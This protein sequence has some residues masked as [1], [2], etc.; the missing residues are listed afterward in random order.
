[1]LKKAFAAIAAAFITQFAWAQTTFLPTYNEDYYILDRL[2]TRSGR[3]SDT[4][5]VANKGE[6]RRNA[7]RFLEAMQGAYADSTAAGKDTATAGGVLSKIDM[8]NLRQMISESGEWAHDENGALYAKK[9]TLKYL[10]PKDYNMAYVKTF[11]FFLVVNPIVSA[12]GMVQLNDPQRANAGTG[13]EIPRVRYAS[14]RGVELRGWIGKKLGF[15]TSFTDN[16]E[17]FPYPVNN[18]AGKTLQAVPGA[19]YFK[20]PTTQF[21]TYDYLQA[22]GYVN[23]DAV[24]DVLNLTFGYGKNSIGDGLTSLYLTDNSASMPYI[25]IQTRIW[26]LNYECLYTEIT[27]QYIKFKD[28]VMGNKYLTLRHLSWNANKWL[29]IGLFES[30]VFHRLQGYEISYFN[31][32][33]LTTAVNKANGS[34]DKS[35]LGLNAKAIVSRHIQLYGQF[36]L[37]EF[38]F[39]E[40]T[41]GKGWYGN[42]YGMQLG[43]KYF[44]VANVNNLD[45]QAELNA[46]RPFAY[47]AQDTLA[48]YTH[49]NQPLAD[50]LGAGFIKA[51]GVLRY[52]P[53]RNWYLSAKATYYIQ[54]V[55]TGNSNLGNNIFKN[56]LTATSQYGVK[57][58]NGPRSTCQIVNLNI[59]YQLRR[60][61]FIDAGG[62]YRQFNLPAS[63][64]AASAGGANIAGPLNTVYAYLGIRLNAARRDYDFF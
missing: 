11:N 59:S 20:R 55:D 19:D 25:R 60:N 24:K 45:A 14:S 63:A 10:Y 6:S 48:N 2:E 36:M 61:L 64:R 37:N 5:R 34:G 13:S 7:V 33:I 16:Q 21:G 57:M 56:Y 8:Y 39:Q 17:Q 12:T 9:M 31:P 4:L 54:G 18:W 44:N 30:E 50:P 23:F 43:A 32:L 40:L 53:A 27:P 47:T 41:G 51:V 35:M 3:L 52:Q 62:S 26:K 38:R 29:N 58:I 46:V 1:M 42:K 15:Y 22:V 49:Y 28:G